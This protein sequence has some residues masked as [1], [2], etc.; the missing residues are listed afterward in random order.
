[1]SYLA[2]STESAKAPLGINPGK[3]RHW[4][5]ESCAA[6]TSTSKHATVQVCM[7]TAKAAVAH[8]GG[9]PAWDAHMHVWVSSELP[10][11]RSLCA[12]QADQMCICA[13]SQGQ[14]PSWLR[15]VVH[16]EAAAADTRRQ[17]NPVSAGWRLRLCRLSCMACC[18]GNSSHWQATAGRSISGW[19]QVQLDMYF[20]EH[21][22]TATAATWPAT[23]SE[24][25]QSK[26]AALASCPCCRYAA[27]NKAVADDM[28][29]S[30][31]QACIA[32]GWPIT[33]GQP[34]NI[35]CR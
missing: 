31:K 17:D 20:S 16:P 24:Q 14:C 8:A 9:A 22:H 3:S 1:M 15:E 30:L 6:P 18:T 21:L 13:V 4:S 10:Q 2:C 19:V 12:P 27:Y 33:G 26:Y 23:R 11:C 35:D 32:L 25:L 7:S 29:N 5:C 34:V 28:T